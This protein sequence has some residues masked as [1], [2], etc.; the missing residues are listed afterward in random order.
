MINGDIVN[1]VELNSCV[2]VIIASYKRSHILKRAYRSYLIDACVKEFILVI[3]SYNDSYDEI[4][5][6]IQEDCIKFSCQFVLI[7]NKKRLG[8]SA[9]R[10]LGLMKST[11]EYVFFSDDDMYIEC[12]GINKLLSKL[13]KTNSH[14]VGPRLFYLN[15]HQYRSGK[16]EEILA[17]K[18]ETDKCID[19]KSIIGD[20]TKKYKEESLNVDFVSAVALFQKQFLVDNKI[21]FFEHYNGNS[22]RE[23]TDIQIQVKKHQGT[24]LFDSSVVCYHLPYMFLRG[25]G[26]RR[27]NIIWYEYWCFVNNWKFLNRHKEFFRSVY[28]ISTIMAQ[29]EFFVKR[30]EILMIKILKRIKDL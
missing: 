11:C 12:D 8:A 20:F 26:Q 7:K 27:G 1:P 28:G 30:I 25:T 19:A 6:A 24:I 14:V 16:I 13:I 3:D 5:L 2:S 4:I 18:E 15:E 10:N 21:V 29:K 23:E 17:A 9:C 22:F